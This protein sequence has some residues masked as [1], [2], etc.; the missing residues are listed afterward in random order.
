MFW[1]VPPPRGPVPPPPTP[2]REPEWFEIAFGAPRAGWIHLTLTLEGVLVTIPNSQVFDPFGHIVRW[3]EALARGGEA[4]CEID[5]EGS[6][7]LL[8]AHPE[9]G[10]DRLRFTIW[11]EEEELCPVCDLRLGRRDLVRAF[12]EALLAVW[13]KPDPETFWRAWRWMD[14]DP[15]AGRYGIRSTVVEDYLATSRPDGAG[16]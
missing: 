2:P 1:H 8:S 6:A 9:P 10:P 4:V 5:M 7:A 11:F 15:E 12:H 3:L 14:K 13:E 16:T